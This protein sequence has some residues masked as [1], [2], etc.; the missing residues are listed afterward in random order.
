MMSRVPPVAV[1]ALGLG[2]AAQQLRKRGWARS[3]VL[4]HP[5]CHFTAAGVVS[6][7]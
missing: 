1:E 5:R 7:S 4:P 3:A 6:P 2:R